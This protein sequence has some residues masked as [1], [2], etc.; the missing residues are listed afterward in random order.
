MTF[1]S[2]L[3][4]RPDLYPP[5]GWKNMQES[6]KSS[7]SPLTVPTIPMCDTEP[8][9]LWYPD[10]IPPKPLR[11]QLAPS[12]KNPGKKPSSQK[13][14]HQ[15]KRE[16]MKSCSCKTSTAKAAVNAACCFFCAAA[17]AEIITS[18]SHPFLILSVSQCITLFFPCQPIHFCLCIPFF[19]E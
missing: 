5:S 11:P 3:P 15:K 16:R 12:V 2:Y 18:S 14:G 1:L 10:Q 19:T 4:A 7:F 8:F 17:C 13:S 6:T 9:L